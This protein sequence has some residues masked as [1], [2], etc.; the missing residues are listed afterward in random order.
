M[1]HN[2][3]YSK[4]KRA[5]QILNGLD[6]LSIKLFN[7]IFVSKYHSRDSVIDLK[8]ENKISGYEEYSKCEKC[9]TAVP[10][11]VEN[12]SLKYITS[13]RAYVRSLGLPGGLNNYYGIRIPLIFEMYNIEF[14]MVDFSKAFDGSLSYYF[15]VL[16]NIQIKA[17]KLVKNKVLMIFASKRKKKELNDEMSL[18]STD[19]YNISA[20]ELN[21]DNSSLNNISVTEANN[22]NISQ[23]EL[24]NNISWTE[25]NNNSSQN[26]LNNENIL[27]NESNNNS[28]NISQ[29]ELN[30]DNILQN[31]LNN[32]NI[33][34]NELNYDNS[35]VN[36]MNNNSESDD[37]ISESEL[38]YNNISQNK[39][40]D[41]KMSEI[42]R[43]YN[44]SRMLLVLP[45]EMSNLKSKKRNKTQAEIEDS[46]FMPKQKKRRIV[47]E[48]IELG[49]KNDFIVKLVIPNVCHIDLDC[50]D[51][52]MQHTTKK[53]DCSGDV[54]MHDTKM[55]D[56]DVTLKD[57]TSD[58]LD[59]IILGILFKK[60]DYKKK[61]IINEAFDERINEMFIYLLIYYYKSGKINEMN[62][63][64]KFI[65]FINGT[66]LDDIDDEA[67]SN[68]NLPFAYYLFK[69][70]VK[71]V[72]LML[73][74]WTS[75]DHEPLKALL[76]LCNS[77][78][79]NVNFKGIYSFYSYSSD[80]GGYRYEM[81]CFNILLALGHMTN[82]NE[83]CFYN[84]YH[85]RVEEVYQILFTER[86]YEYDC[87][88][89]K[90]LCVSKIL[91]CSEFKL[92]A[93]ELVCV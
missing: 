8:D 69:N 62:E 52:D 22:N 90:K 38:N 33:S 4:Y 13:L 45:N 42:E 43:Q 47:I 26:E 25:A 32:N 30:N 27:Q 40:N 15:E 60:I 24:N 67:F 92:S 58:N 86:E 16:F 82:K 68:K 53:E 34:Q 35:S 48:P 29:N 72:Q 1:R 85:Q 84:I 9:F 14:E 49:S 91:K 63:C 18:Y 73:D 50:G 37:N 36:N 19:S 56:C 83:Y 78:F 28:Y 87:N 46:D 89:L 57:I 41:I 11:F 80:Y 55:E 54:D 3:T 21:N 7:I 79:R 81:K 77:K 75:V 74:N 39:L 65:C 59:N 6:Y 10:F 31:E 66:E 5:L 70:D 2:E 71:N 64:M 17:N 61:F 51:V 23:N 20:N 88:I 12:S 76:Y 44:V 93:L